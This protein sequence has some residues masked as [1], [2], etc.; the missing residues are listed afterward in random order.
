M[1]GGILGL[2]IGH[3]IAA[4]GSAYLKRLVGQGF[5]WHTIAWPELAFLGAVVIIAFLAGLV[6]A[7]KAYQAPVADNL[8]NT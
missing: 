1:V 2:I 4:G 6:P 5:A 3:L 8:V 7:L